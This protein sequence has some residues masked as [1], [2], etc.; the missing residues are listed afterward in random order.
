MKITRVVHKTYD[1][2]DDILIEYI[3]YCNQENI[4]PE[5]NDFVFWLDEQYDLWGFL[6]EEDNDWECINNSFNLNKEFKKE[7]N[8]L[9]ND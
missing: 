4:T 1:I 7:I 9:K 2:D 5:L 8:R 6:C 3:S